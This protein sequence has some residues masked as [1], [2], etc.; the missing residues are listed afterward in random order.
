MGGIARLEI[1]LYNLYLLLVP[2]I[3]HHLEGSD[4]M[5]CYATLVENLINL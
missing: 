5:K 3:S 1:E 2:E 4:F